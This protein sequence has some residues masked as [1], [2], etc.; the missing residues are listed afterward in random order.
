[1]KKFNFSILLF[2][3]VLMASTQ[4]FAQLA[5]DKGTKF[6]NLGIGVG[7]YGGIGFGGGGVAFGGS[8]E[9][10]VAKNITV[11]G[12]AS[13]RSYS[14]FGSYYSIGARGS[15]HFN[16]LLSLTTDKADLYA[17]L[18]LIY[19]GFSY[20]DGFLSSAYNYGGI[21]LGLHIGGRYFFS[22]RVGGFAEVG[23]GV[24][25]LQLGVT[26]KL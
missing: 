17:G 20:K 23:V 3:L 7:G 5:V 26:F 6:L 11:G 15:Y 21:D 12:I 9:A 25:P 4:S 24:A 1:M 22:E 18:G 8:F 2:A 13:F 19:S 14:N 10:G 16:E